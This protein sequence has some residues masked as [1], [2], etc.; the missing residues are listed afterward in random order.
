MLQKHEWPKSF[1]KLSVNSIPSS[2]AKRTTSR[3]QNNLIRT[4]GENI[5]AIITDKIK[6][7]QNTA[8]LTFEK[9]LTLTNEKIPEYIFELEAVAVLLKDDAFRAVCNLPNFKKEEFHQIGIF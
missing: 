7:G 4:H 6:G 9:N 2:F 1:E 8:I 3:T 5:P